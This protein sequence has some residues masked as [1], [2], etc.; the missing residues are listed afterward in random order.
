MNVDLGVGD[1][2]LRVGRRFPTPDTY[3][4][5]DKERLYFSPFLDELSLRLIRQLGALREALGYKAFR[6]EREDVSRISGAVGIKE[7]LDDH[8][9]GSLCVDVV[10]PGRDS[11]AFVGSW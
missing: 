10:H 2:R 7:P 5:L 1:I 6:E 11:F 3:F 4:N 8:Q 9:L